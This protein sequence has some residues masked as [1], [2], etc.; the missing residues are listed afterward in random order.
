MIPKRA[1][2]YRGAN[3]AIAACRDQV[4]LISDYLT[5]DLTQPERR[6][7]EAHLGACRD[8]GAFLATY[9]KTIEMTRS[10]LRGR[11][12]N[13]PQPQLQLGRWR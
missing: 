12:N 11:R 6:A 10:F 8:C 7:F 3:R 4:D 2:K 5:N 1:G 13:Q 9:K